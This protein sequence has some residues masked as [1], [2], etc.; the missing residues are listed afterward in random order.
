MRRALLTPSFIVSQPAEARAAGSIFIRTQLRRQR[1]FGG[2]ARRS[3]AG[4][5]AGASP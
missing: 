2:P 5:L 1:L 4:G 3:S